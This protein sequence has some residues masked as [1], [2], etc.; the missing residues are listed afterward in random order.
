[1]DAI[2]D[3]GCTALHAAALM[4]HPAAVQVLLDV[5]ASVDAVTHSGCTA[6]HMA[7]K[8]GHTSVVQLLL[9]AHAAVDALA[10]SHRTPLHTAAS[11]GHA[12]VVQLLLGAHAAV[13]VADADG[14]TALHMAGLTGNTQV[15]QLLLN[16]QSDINR[17]SLFTAV[18]PRG[19]MTPVH[20]AAASGHL[21]AVQLLTSGPQLSAQ[22]LVGTAAAAA[23]VGHTEVAVVLLRA[24]MVRDREAAAVEVAKSRSLATEVL[25]LLQEA[26]D[27]LKEQEARWPVLQQLLVGAATAHQQLRNASVELA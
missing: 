6:L 1:M 15:I 24:L 17:R 11:S 26:E 5:C 13:D 20:Y 7:A 18:V 2:S 4:N 3:S 27:R 25:R 16:A 8:M 12:A 23:A 19:V 9:G 14:C 10:D 21:E 22:T